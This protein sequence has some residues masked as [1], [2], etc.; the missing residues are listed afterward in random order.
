[1]ES[2][3]IYGQKTVM[4]E[5]TQGIE[6]AKQLRFHLNSAEARQFFIQKILS[7]YENALFG[8]TSGEFSRQP[9]ETSLGA[10]SLPESSTSTQSPQCGKFEFDQPH[11]YQHSQNAV[12]KK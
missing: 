6:M 7:S 9:W 11:I 2:A 10:P 8:L 4:N 1:M 5:L 12:S 3:C